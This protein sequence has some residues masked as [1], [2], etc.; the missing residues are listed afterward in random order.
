[1]VSISVVVV[2][3]LGHGLMGMRDC[4]RERQ[5]GRR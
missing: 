2:F 4:Q 3:T 5:R 1:V